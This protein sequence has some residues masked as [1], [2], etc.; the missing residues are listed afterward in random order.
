MLYTPHFLYVAN[1]STLID[2]PYSNPPYLL[3][4]LNTQ[5]FELI[6]IYRRFTLF[7][8]LKKLIAA[9]FRILQLYF[10]LSGVLADE[11]WCETSLMVS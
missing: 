2:K 6:F 8:F 9:L 4:F 5:T 7:N 3:H 1:G 10:F 11:A